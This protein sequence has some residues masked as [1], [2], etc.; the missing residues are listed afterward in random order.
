M[1]RKQFTVVVVVLLIAAGWALVGETQSSPNTTHVYFFVAPAL[2]PD[3]SSSDTEILALKTFLVET[4]GG[5]SG[6]GQSEG[7]WQ[8]LQGKLETEINH[9]FFVSCPKD[10][11]NELSQF[12]HDHFGQSEPY[13]ITWEASSPNST[14]TSSIPFWTEKK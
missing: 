14:Y 9:P 6:L 2:L 12:L 8:N 13:I 4:A 3:G 1:S 10:I 7:G 5:Y 11:S